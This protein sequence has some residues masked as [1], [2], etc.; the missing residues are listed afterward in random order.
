MHTAK[1]P[2]EVYWTARFDYQPRWTLRLHRHSF[3]QIIC[4]RDGEGRFFLDGGEYPLSAGMVF[5]IKPGQIHGLRASSLV[6]TL[7]IKFKI[8]DAGL[9]RRL[10]AARSFITKEGRLPSLVEQIRREGEHRGLFFRELCDVYLLEFLIGY[11]RESAGISDMPK[12]ADESVLPVSRAD[13]FTGR[14]IEFIRRHYAED[15]TGECIAKSLG[16]SDRYLRQRF[17]EAVG[18]PPIHY[19]ARYRVEKAKDRIQY[20]GDPLKVIAETTGFKSIHHFNHVFA[21]IVGDTPG[22][23]RRRYRDGICK[24]VCI[25]PRFSNVILISQE[26]NERSALPARRVSR[27]YKAQS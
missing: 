6:R 9:K 27:E 8:G 12:T 22:A 14:A 21:E 18:M 26:E 5:L 3:F 4:F 13:G 10:L 19:L 20:S 24:D 1:P 23:W 11:L 16:V 2:I 15:L 25:D 17:K 7:D